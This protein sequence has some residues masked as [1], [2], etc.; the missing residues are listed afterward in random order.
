M[1]TSRIAT[2][3]FKQ[4][5]LHFG[6]PGVEVPKQSQSP[7][8][9]YGHIRPQG[10]AGAGSVREHELAFSELGMKEWPYSSLHITHY[11]TLQSLFHLLF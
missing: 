8:E 5:L 7:G 3:F 11:S 1:N 9:P 2:T 6:A 4:G 10:I